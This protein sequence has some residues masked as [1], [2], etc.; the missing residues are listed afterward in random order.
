MD[1]EALRN[2]YR[3]SRVNILFVGEAPPAS[4]R[5]FYQ[6]DSGLYRA[7]QTA[8][9]SAFPSLQNT[10]FLDAFKTLGCYLVDLCDS[11]VDRFPQK[12]R[13]LTCAASEASLARKICNISPK[14]MVTVVR[15]IAANVR[16]ALQAANWSGEYVELPYPG[17]W[18]Q[19]QV[20][21]QKVLV[22]LLR[23]ELPGPESS[24][25]FRHLIL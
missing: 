20:A 23:R 16:H 3:P 10:E 2:K 5:F 8:F 24:L 14:I 12:T 21:F 4:G 7:F 17:R 1:F 19:H 25:G 11:P 6:A 13:A 22:P 9:T 18:R 15:S